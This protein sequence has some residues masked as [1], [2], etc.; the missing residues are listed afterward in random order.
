MNSDR[1]SITTQRHHAAPALGNSS[2]S[3]ELARDSRE[4]SRDVFRTGALIVNADD[5]GRDVE[6]TDRTL[7]CIDR[8]T[9]SS[10][11]GM[12]FMKDS[13][14][15]A[16]LARERGMDV[17]LHLNL[18]T[19]FSASNISPALVDHQERISRYLGKRRLSQVV[20]NPGLSNSFQYV[21][22]A[23]RDEFRRLY[24]TQPQRIDGHHHMH[25]CANVRLQ[26]LL[27][28]A[29]IV[30]RNFSFQPG[31]KSVWN[32]LYRRRVDKSLARRHA[33]TDYFFSLPPFEPRE[34]LDRMRELS[35]QFI[36]EVETHPVKKDEYEFL[37][38][39][40]A[41]RWAADAPIANGFSS[42][43]GNRTDRLGERS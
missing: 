15:A 6:N 38:G 30:R 23:Q 35:R 37:A 1:V 16:E 40:E 42:S 41:E 11:S 36:V 26:K 22:A 27:P 14:R 25:L 9:V 21:V 20:F 2:V 19:E 33:L 28:P 10:V 43:M 13:E 8:R 4:S 18:T 12:V 34:R 3:S 5:W 24:G 32:R 31:E 17:G 39:R 7:E 29:T